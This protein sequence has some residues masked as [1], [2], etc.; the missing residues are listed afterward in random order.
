MNLRN[1]IYG[2]QEDAYKKTP[3][4][5]IISL[6]A[7]A[8]SGLATN[9]VISNIPTGLD[10]SRLRFVNHF[11]V[12][13]RKWYDPEVGIKS[14]FDPTNRWTSKGSATVKEFVWN[15]MKASE[16]Q[17]GRIGRTFSLSSIYGKGI[18]SQGKFD[19][20]E[21]IVEKNF[22]YLRHISEGRINKTTIEKGLRYEPGTRFRAGKLFS[23]SDQ[24]LDNASIMP[25]RWAKD[26]FIDGKRVGY[27]S[28]FVEALQS[29]H[30]LKT[31]E[32]DIFI[33][34]G[35]GRIKPFGRSLNAFATV[36]TENYMRLLDDPF[37]LLSNEIERFA[38]KATK[39]SKA[40]GWASKNLW[41]KAFL[42]NQFGVGGAEF[43]KKGDAIS[44]MKRHAMRGLPKI[45]MAIGAYKLLDWTLRSTPL[46]KETGLGL[47]VSG[48]AAKAAQGVR[49]GYA[50]TSDITGMTAL[51]KWQE[52]EARG[53]TSLLGLAAFPASFAITGATIG[54][55]A[56]LAQQ[57]P[58]GEKAPA[59]ELFSRLFSNLESKNNK[60]G[61]VAE[62]FNFSK[63]GRTGAFA[64]TG[65]ALG[66]AAILPF[67]PG[68]LGSSK[69]EEELELIHSGEELV[70]IRRGR[71]WEFG[72]SPYEGSDIEYF[73]PHW[74]VR[75]MSD[76]ATKGRLPEEYYENPLLMMAERALDPYALEKRL[77]EERPYTY[78]GASDLGLGFMERL[79]FPVKEAFK[80]T[81]QAHPEAM[82]GIHPAQQRKYG[83]EAPLS[84]AGTGQE[85]TTYGYLPEVQSPSGF[86]VR[87]ADIIQSGIDVAGLQG[88]AAS[89]LFTSISGGQSFVTPNAV[90]EHSGRIM[91]SQRAYWEQNLGGM[92]GLNEAYR[93]LNPDRPYATENVSSAIRNTMPDWIPEGRLR[94]GDPYAQIDQ[95]ELRLPGRGYAALHSELEGV[96]YEDYPLVHR[97]NIL[98]SVA[99]MSPEYFQHESLVASQVAEGDLNQAGVNL[100]E[101]ILRQRDLKENED[102]FDYGEGAL[103]SYY[104]GLKK[105]GRSLPTES[106]YPL[107]PVHKF[108]GPTDPINEYKSFEVLDKQFK[109]W[110]NPIEDYLT[111]T[112]NKTV[113]FF[114][115]TDY[116]PPSA[117]EHAEIESYFSALQATKNQLLDQR[118]N[119]AAEAGDF[120]ASSFFR[121]GKR[122][123][124][125]G[126]DPY[127]DIQE[128]E[129]LLPRRQRRYVDALMKTDDRKRALNIVTPEMQQILAAQWSKANYLQANDF[130]RLQ[131]VQRNMTPIAGAAEAELGDTAPDQDW[132]GYAPGVDL[133]AFK[134]KTVNHMGK[135]IRDFNLWREDER[136]AQVLDAHLRS[137]D[138]SMT[139]LQQPSPELSKRALQEYLQSIGMQGARIT[140]IPIAGNTT[141]NLQ[142]N[143]NNKNSIREEMRDQGWINI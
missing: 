32:T 63:L 11:T 66:A 79:I 60:I 40:S 75:A 43:L 80:P 122:R 116:V 61:K 120:E 27:T 31:S 129:Q 22:E 20:P 98:N 140:A 18:L 5:S 24:L 62:A 85:I 50:F 13:G 53:S 21:D 37:E 125:H 51:S 68:A 71:F 67:L 8:A 121:S 103:G 104:L 44:L 38:G 127:G 94:Y 14:K 111:P 110:Q 113:D 70:P 88:F 55:I 59:P 35:Q 90:H 91:S 52:E 26:Q 114:S 73:A 30:G 76:A 115:L 100:Y 136:N 87:M 143:Q 39:I 33:T 17:L 133:N 29:I 4:E 107:S 6:A 118:A 112:F 12:G 128:L 46:I 65:A 2:S 10:P 28:R 138:L 82:G 41:E 95:G 126:A 99:P 141:V 134:L 123:T 119:A 15:A 97:M 93:R 48:L 92:F 135:N 106:L 101:E 83:T 58:I 131:Q 7:I 74:T 3:T 1:E 86:Q 81:I 139:R 109:L 45:A 42:K 130:E 34:G 9:T 36:F 108:A 25:G 132:I 137:A 47:G 69:S 124:L 56:G 102:R 57:V 19:I 64:L 96:N 89:E 84:L 54:G 117:Q 23:G 49:E 77:D 78:W 16:E 72:T 142:L 105:F